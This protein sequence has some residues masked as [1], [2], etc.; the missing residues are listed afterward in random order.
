MVS[1]SCEVA[2]CSLPLVRLVAS[3]RGRLSECSLPLA[4][5]AASTRGGT[6]GT[7][8]N[9]DQRGDTT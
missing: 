1:A 6:G 3:D 7:G 9:P 5:L 2:D 4:R 8:V